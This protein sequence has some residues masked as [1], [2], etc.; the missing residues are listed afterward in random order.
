MLELE[1]SGAHN[2]NFVTPTHYVPSIIK[3]IKA[4][5]CGGLEIPIVYNTASYEKPETIRSLSDTVDV[6]LPDLKYYREETAK[7]YSAA[8]NYPTVARRAIE[9]MVKTKGPAALSEDGMIKRGVVVRVLLLPGHLAEAKLNVKHLYESYGDDIYI[10]LMS[11]YTPPKDMSPPLN[12]RV[13]K[14][15][16]YELCDYADSLGIIRGFTQDFESAEESF[17]PPFDNSGVLNLK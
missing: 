13:T 5:R 17:I 4:A 9:E 11:Q 10:S 6:Y 3:A 7:R 16:Y 1:A 2:I 15:E 14:A 8:E 12:R